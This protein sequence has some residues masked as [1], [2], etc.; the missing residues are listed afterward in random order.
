MTIFRSFLVIEL[1]EYGGLPAR[2][3]SMGC[4]LN[5]VEATRILSIVA[6]FFEAALSVAMDF[7]NDVI[8][9]GLSVADLLV[10]T[11][12]MIGPPFG[13]SSIAG[14]PMIALP[15]ATQAAANG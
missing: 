3:T 4:L 1:K 10:V 6:L 5:L 11:H 15:S 9:A 2:T 12:I 8:T 14:W 13:M 7:W